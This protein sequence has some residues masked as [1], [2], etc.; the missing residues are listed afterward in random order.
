MPGVPG[1]KTRDEVLSASI[2][3]HPYSDGTGHCC[4]EE[5]P[6]WNVDERKTRK[7]WQVLFFYAK[8]FEKNCCPTI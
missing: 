1:T 6:L 4:F 5:I 2:L 8:R 7:N 3:Y